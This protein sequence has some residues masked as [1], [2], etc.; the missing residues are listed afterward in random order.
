MSGDEWTADTS[1]RRRGCL[2]EDL[3]AA[4]GRVVRRYPA[5]RLV[6]NRVGNLAVM[7]GEEQVGTLDLTFAR[8]EAYEAGDD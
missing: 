8:F 1:V 7:D 6:R 5:A 4:L 2:A 3:L